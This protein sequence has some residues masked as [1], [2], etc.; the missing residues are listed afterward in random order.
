MK[1]HRLRNQL[2]FPVVVRFF[3]GHICHRFGTFLCLT[4]GLLLASTNAALGA[5]GAAQPPRNYL[6]NASA[7][8]ATLLAT[9]D[10]VVFP[11][12]PLGVSDSQTIQ[13]KNIGSSIVTISSATISG[14]GFTLTGLTLPLWRPV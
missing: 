11:G 13:L 6:S 9:P 12:A 8:A 14:T 2:L 5:A 7:G 3:S 4:L 1:V 10:S